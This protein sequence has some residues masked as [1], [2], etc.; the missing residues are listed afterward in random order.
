MPNTDHD[1]VIALAGLFLATTLVRDIARNGRV[2]SDDFATCL[3]SLLK[4]DAA[5]NEDV[6]G[7]VSQLHSGLRQL[8]RHLSNPKDMEIT[9]Y[10]VALLVLERKLAR[11]TAMLQRIREGLEATV[12]KLS[13]FPLGHENIIAGLADIYA[14]T[15][16]TLTPRI[17][18][19]GERVHLTN[20]D[21]TNRIRT[22][23]LAGV[24]AARLWRQSGG[25]RLTLL[26]R[27]RVLLLE[28][29]HILATL[30][31]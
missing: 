13:Y 22:L 19:N 8:K 6:Y 18:V 30:G 12:D 27:R 21:N 2:D 15:V 14:A 4:I 7:S 17:M 29:Q 24:R 23:L 5:S 9:R 10:V 28:T 20:P 26:F 31:D 1:R 25:G 3:G 11:H 16:S